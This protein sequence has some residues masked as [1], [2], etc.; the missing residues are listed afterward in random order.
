MSSIF[1]TNSRPSCL[2]NSALVYDP[3]CGGRGKVAG[4]QPMSTAVYLTFCFNVLPGTRLH[5]LP[6]YSLCQPSCI[7]FFFY[8][9][10]LSYDPERD[11]IGSGL[12]KNSKSSKPALTIGLP[13]FGMVPH[14]VTRQVP[15]S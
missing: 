15:Y 5:G 6:I 12:R 13:N 1:L 9:T 3:K 2:T 4:S 11:R 8:C 14:Q 10:S 7:L